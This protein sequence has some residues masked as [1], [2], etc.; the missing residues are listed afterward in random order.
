MSKIVKVEFAKLKR[1]KDLTI[2]FPEKGVVALMGENGIGKSTVLH[3]LA[4]IYRPHQ[5]TQVGKG[6]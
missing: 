4:C 3:A 6:M 2:E 5:H 1:L